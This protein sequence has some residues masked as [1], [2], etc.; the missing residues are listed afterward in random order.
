MW[1]QRRQR[2]A[3]YAVDWTRWAGAQANGG[4][5]SD[6]ADRALIWR[7]RR[8]SRKFSRMTVSSSAT[9]A[10]SLASPDPLPPPCV[11]AF[12]N[13]PHRWRAP[14]L[15]RDGPRPGGGSS[16]IWRLR[17]AILLSVIATSSHPTSPA[18]FSRSSS[19][20]LRG[21]SLR[22]IVRYS[23]CVIIMAVVSISVQTLSTRRVK[24]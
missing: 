21:R 19:L 2:L 5:G 11:P 18:V 24:R 17:K 14:R 10:S 16:S 15:R 6:A 1:H 13:H 22:S 8:G 7:G 23:H 9:S 3:R 20:T 12:P 4:S